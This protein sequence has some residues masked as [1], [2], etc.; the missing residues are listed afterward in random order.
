MSAADTTQTQTT[1][2]L[3]SAILRNMQ[4]FDSEVCF[5]FDP[6]V[7]VLIGPNGV[8]KSRALG[9]FAGVRQIRFSS[10]PDEPEREVERFME[11]DDDPDSITAVYVG[12]T[13]IPL[14]PDTVL[15]DLQQFDIQEKL[16]RLFNVVRRLA[17][18]AS[19]VGLV[20]LTLAMIGDTYPNLVPWPTDIGL[21]GI[22]TIAIIVWVGNIAYIFASWA[23]RHPLR[24]VPSNRLLSSMLTD[25]S[26]VS[27]VFM[28]QAV[29]VANH[30]LLSAGG[31]LGGNRRSA[32]ALEAAELALSCAKSIAPE[33]FPPKATLH[34]G[35]V[36][37]SDAS[38]QTKW[39]SWWRTRF[40]VNHL[41]SVDTRYSP[42][43]L[44]IADLSSGT[45]GP[46]LIA[47]YLA[48]KLVYSHR[49][50]RGWEGRPAILFIDEIENHLHPVWQRRFIPAFLEH[51][52]SLQIFATTHSP[53]TVVGQKAGQVHKLFQ[54]NEGETIVETNEYDLVGWTSDEIL[55]SYLDVCD[56]TDLET[57]QA[58]EVLRWLDQLD[59][60][61]EEESA[62]SWR[63][64][65]L[66]DLI[67]LIEQDE[68]TS[69]DAIVARWLSGQ[70]NAPVPLSPPLLGEAEAWKKAA[71]S[72]F[73]SVAG[74]DVLSGGP[75]ARQRQ[76][77]DQQIA[78]GTFRVS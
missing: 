48:L 40:F 10:D 31:H 76:I 71:L 49:F 52:P 46:L 6:K 34:T 8:G 5:Q 47:W 19:S 23:R 44:H 75:A 67:D 37:A 62:E 43:P 17:L 38:S 74:V 60:L 50:Q 59:D 13:R 36:M 77:R 61:T 39:L 9:A 63:T 28:F 12:P 1:P 53:F 4:P 58:V 18:F 26:V 33:V 25:R 2:Y 72:E 69:E 41:S 22:A 64:A 3:R 78:D 30:R 65:V 16:I 35:A 32:A 11:P 68:A 66:D 21:G 27:S 14:D 29:Q 20:I 24:F 57:A 55:H 54:G 42:I 70:I 7:N 45:Q 51:F 56:P 15:Q 73:R